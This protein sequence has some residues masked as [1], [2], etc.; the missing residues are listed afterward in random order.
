M[1][2]GNFWVGFQP[3]DKP[4][5]RPKQ[6]NPDAGGNWAQG[7]DGFK[8]LTFGQLAQLWTEVWVNETSSSASPVQRVQSSSAASLIR[9]VK[10]HDCYRHLIVK[11]QGA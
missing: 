11:Q 9:L 4:G 2:L 6:L 8:G 3:V 1:L 7:E 10:A 5:D